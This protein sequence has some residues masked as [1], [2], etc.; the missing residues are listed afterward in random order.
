MHTTY[1][2]TLGLDA[3][4]LTAIL[5]NAPHKIG[6]YLY[7]TSLKCLSMQ[8]FLQNTTDN[9]I[10]IL[11]GGCYNQEVEKTIQKENILILT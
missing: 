1:L 2:L 6:K 10:L 4:R 7:G 3:S 9:C 11:N 8:E 5:D